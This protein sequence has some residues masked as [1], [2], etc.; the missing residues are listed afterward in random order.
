MVRVRDRGDRLVY[1]PVVSRVLIVV[2]AAFGVWWDVDLLLARPGVGVLSVMWLIAACTLLIALFWR[3][4]VIVDGEGA[5]LRNVLRDVRV[6]WTA[7]E[8]VETRYAL[9]L[10]AAGRRYTSWAGAAG[11]KPSRIRASEAPLPGRE[12]EPLLASRDLRTP[13]GAT[14]FMVEQ[15]WELWRTESRR[16]AYLASRRLQASGEGTAPEAGDGVGRGATAEA[17]PG[18]VVV[19][20]RLRLVGAGVATAALAGVL[21]PLLR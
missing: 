17:T 9:T 2:F 13:S 15:R 10:V 1:Q 4:A 14:A 3:P 19:E 18:P 12:H 8:A 21:T 20:W 6:P 5:E 16:R 11:G 7:L